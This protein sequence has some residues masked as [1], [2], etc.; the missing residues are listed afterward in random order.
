MRAMYADEEYKRH[1]RLKKY[2]K[3]SI[4]FIAHRVDRYV[5]HKN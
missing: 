3:M 5:Q 4:K 1:I 2:M